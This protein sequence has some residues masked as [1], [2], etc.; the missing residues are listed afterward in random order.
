MPNASTVNF[1]LEKLFN[2][3]CFFKKDVRVCDDHSCLN[4]GTCVVYLGG[5]LCRCQTGF[6]GRSCEISNQRVLKCNQFNCIHGNCSNEGKCICHEGW[7]SDQCN[8]STKS[9]RLGE[10]KSELDLSFEEYRGVLVSHV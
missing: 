3:T 5:Y 9:F 4:N 8:Q 10:K 6:S 7:T 2:G 1:L